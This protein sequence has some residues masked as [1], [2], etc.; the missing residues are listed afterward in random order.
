MKSQKNQ[1]EQYNTLDSSMSVNNKMLALYVLCKPWTY[2]F[3][4]SYKHFYNTYYIQIKGV[5]DLIF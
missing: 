1:Y 3:L 5:Y 4:I 2:I